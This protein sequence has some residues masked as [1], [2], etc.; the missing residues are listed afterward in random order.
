MRLRWNLAAALANTGWG[1][2]IG[3]AVVPFYLRFLGL[4]AYGLI[5]FFTA[6]QGL[7]VVLDMGL[8]PTMTREVARCRATGKIGEARDLLRTLAVLYWGIGILIAA[9]ML[10][11]ATFIADHWLRDSALSPDTVRQAIMLMGVTIA[12]RWPLGLYLGALMGAEQMVRASMISIVMITIANGGALA[13]LAFVSPT[14]QAFFIWQ[15]FAGLLNVVVMM[16]AAWAAVRGEGRPR[17]DVQGLKRIWRFSA[18]MGVAGILG[19]VFM[20]SD[21]IV[22]A[23]IVSLD[24]LGQY[25]LAGVVARLLYV[26]MTPAFNVTYPRMTALHS[27]G[28]E[29]ELREFY[30]WGTRLLAAVIFPL[31][32]YVSV[33]ADPLVALWTGNAQLGVA[34]APVVQLLMAGTALNAV[35]QFP[36]ALQLASGRSHLAALISAILLCIFIPML[37]ILASTLGIVGAAAAWAIFNFLYLILGTWM[38]HRV[39]LPGLALHWLARDVALPFAIT[40]GLV[41]GGGMALRWGGLGTWPSL[42]LGG[43]LALLAFLLSIGSSFRARKVLQEWK[44]DRTKPF[45][46]N[47][48]A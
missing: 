6:L 23:R 3:L 40:A 27:A 43:C 26:V 8:T 24:E 14:I 44:V 37:I 36:Y 17:F 15:A 47:I 22:L 42:L 29:A 1:A 31:A 12:C 38:T 19:V 33:F 39:I 48:V 25:A 10:L 30:L 16:F 4:E 45:D 28:N 35:M 13:I 46:L 20:Q 21:K 11:S 2:L 32:A 9:A 34:V 18:G 41:V 5:G 7:F